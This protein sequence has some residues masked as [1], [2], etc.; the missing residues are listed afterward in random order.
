MLL[1]DR[2]VPKAIRTMRKAHQFYRQLQSAICSI[3][4]ET[5]GRMDTWARWQMKKTLC[6]FA[7]TIKK[8][9]KNAPRFLAWILTM[10]SLLRRLRR[11]PLRPR[12]EENKTELLSKISMTWKTPRHTKTNTS[13]M[14]SQVRAKRND[15]FLLIKLSAHS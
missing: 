1:R 9:S 10:Y 5:S 13:K 12:R 4:S 8:V 7:L 14:H 3:A 11:C 15:C 2:K 6:W